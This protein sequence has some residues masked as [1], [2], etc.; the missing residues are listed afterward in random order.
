MTDWYQR[1]WYECANQTDGYVFT[2]PQDASTV[3]AAGVL[4]YVIATHVVACTD[5]QILKGVSKLPL[6]E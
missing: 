6:Y 1:K 3:A 2:V 5:T 4:T